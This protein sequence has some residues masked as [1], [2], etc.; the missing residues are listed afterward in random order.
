MTFES[1]PALAQAAFIP[2]DL[3]QKIIFFAGAML[4]RKTAKDYLTLA[5]VRITSGFNK[6]QREHKIP[7][8]LASA[9]LM[10]GGSLA[11]Y[12]IYSLSGYS[13]L[14]GI[15]FSVHGIFM[16]DVA[17]A[18]RS[19]A[20]CGIV[21]FRSLIENLVF[22]QNKMNFIMDQDTTDLI[23]SRAEKVASA[24][25]LV[26]SIGLTILCGNPIIAGTVAHPLAAIVKGVALH[27][28]TES[29]IHSPQM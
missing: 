17:Y 5:S 18:P 21:S 11:A 27:V 8:P 13:L 22:D 6:L 20:A 9:A 16:R 15:I 2:G 25:L 19:P 1:L 28:L 23:D 26:T 10:A 24:A 29:T 14:S 3:L 12:A 7:R 4:L